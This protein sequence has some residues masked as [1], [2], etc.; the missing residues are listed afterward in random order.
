MTR[1]DWDRETREARKRKHG[2]VPLW[3]D[4]GPISF[5]DDQHIRTLLK[6]LTE[7][8]EEFADLSA[9]QRRQRGSEFSYRL[10]RQAKQAAAS[11][12]LADTD[13]REVLAAR[14]G[15]LIERLQQLESSTAQ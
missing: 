10:R 5:E 1:L 15:R 7:T 2:A 13:A 9:T 14:A 6:P 4:S 8:V 11:S 12:E 3:A